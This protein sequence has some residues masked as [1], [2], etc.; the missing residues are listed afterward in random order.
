MSLDKI[1]LI[2]HLSRELNLIGYKKLPFKSRTK[3]K[4]KIEENSE[5][6]SE[7]ENENVKIVFDSRRMVCE[8]VSVCIDLVKHIK[9]K[10]FLTSE[11]DHLNKLNFENHKLERQLASVKN[12]VEKKTA[13]LANEKA[14]NSQL[15]ERIHK[16]E[17]NMAEIELDR[18]KV[19]QKCETN[20][21]LLKHS[22]KKQ[23]DNVRE[24]HTIIWKQF[25]MADKNYFPENFK[26]IQIQQPDFN[27]L[28]S[29]VKYSSPIGKEEAL[30]KAVCILQENNNLLMEDNYLLKNLL[31]TTLEEVNESIQF[32][33]GKMHLVNDQQVLL[34]EKVSEIF[35]NVEDLNVKLYRKT[36]SEYFDVIKSAAELFEAASFT[37]SDDLFVCWSDILQQIKTLKDNKEHI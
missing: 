14:K 26:I 23:Q 2:P 22:L 25:N 35:Q 11:N 8:L 16:L 10:G 31:L 1:L 4:K 15:S 3:Y 19:I 29:D 36:I 13:E 17:K 9:T 7:N 37:V 32:L 24:L 12:E 6:D 21:D 28:W 30:K 27:K 18:K 33:C 34:T 20:E 5:S